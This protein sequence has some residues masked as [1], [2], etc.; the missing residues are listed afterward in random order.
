VRFQS[1][2]EV[3]STG[4]ALFVLPLQTAAPL[5]ELSVHVAV[6]QSA[7]A[8]EVRDSDIAKLH[9][10]P[11]KGEEH[12]HIAAVQLSNVKL[13]RSLVVAVP[14]VPVEAQLQAVSANGTSATLRPNGIA[15]A[16]KRAERHTLA[17]EHHFALFELPKVDAASAAGTGK[18]G[19]RVRIVWDASLSRE[20]VRFRPNHCAAIGRMHCR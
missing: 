14:K 18:P 8:P 7:Q 9:F 2:L 6:K 4:D 16:E 17:G 13:S 20:K 11:A 1:E 3:T 5:S 10:E 15:T 19:K 12:S